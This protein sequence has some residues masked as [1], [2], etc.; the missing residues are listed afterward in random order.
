MKPLDL[1]AGVRVSDYDRAVA[2]YRQLLG[3]EPSF[4]PNDSEAVWQL[5]EHS[6]LYV[7][8]R[9]PALAGHAVHTI[10]VDDLEAV[11]E[12]TAARG[13]EPAGE[14]AYPNGVRK[15]T[16]RDADGNEIGFAGAQ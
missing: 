11:V 14:E 7:D 9:L 10:F 4:L 13:I 2:W 8:A 1:F 12:Q 5:G 6:W 15:V 16:Y 3:A